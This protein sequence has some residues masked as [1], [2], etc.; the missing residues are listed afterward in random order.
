MSSTKTVTWPLPPRTLTPR[1]VSRVTAATTDFC[2]NYPGGDTR[3]ELGMAALA[4]RSNPFA[5][6]GLADLP[7]TA[8]RA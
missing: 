4:T 8:R 2:K 6:Q 3:L 5:D 7:G 1:S